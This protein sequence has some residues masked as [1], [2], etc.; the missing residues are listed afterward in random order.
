MS[1]LSRKWNKMFTIEIEPSI[2]YPDDKDRWERYGEPLSRLFDPF[3]LGEKIFQWFKDDSEK[4][5]TGVNVACFKSSHSWK[6]SLNGQ[7]DIELFASLYTPVNEFFVRLGSC[8]SITGIFNIIGSPV[9]MVVKAEASR[10]S[11]DRNIFSN[12]LPVEL[13][14]PDLE[15]QMDMIN[16]DNRYYVVYIGR[17]TGCKRFKEITKDQAISI[18]GEN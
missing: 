9:N 17:Q 18:A 12:Q 2:S 13:D 4:F 1:L 5:L 16:H 11:G 14:E 7:K 3:F 6:G 8:A 10:L 15:K